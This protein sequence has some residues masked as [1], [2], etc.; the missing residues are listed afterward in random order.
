MFG[1]FESVYFSVFA[2][3]GISSEE[4]TLLY[5]AVQMKYAP[6]VQ[7]LLDHKADPEKLTLDGRSLLDIA[8]ANQDE[9]TVEVLRQAIV[10]RYILKG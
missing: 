2:A 9:A 6:T 8:I 3:S 10:A 5:H 7:V 4:D 1:D